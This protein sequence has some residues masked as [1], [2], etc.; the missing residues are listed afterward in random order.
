MFVTSCEDPEIISR[1]RPESAFNDAPGGTS[2]CS[3]CSNPAASAY[4]GVTIRVMNPTEPPIGAVRAALAIGTAM[5]KPP[6]CTSPTPLSCNELV[7]TP[8]TA[9]RGMGAP[10]C[11]VMLP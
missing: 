2:G 9:E 4:C 8:I 5:Y 1:L 10:V 11:N 6:C 3:A 7:S